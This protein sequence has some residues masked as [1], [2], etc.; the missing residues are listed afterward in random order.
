MEDAALHCQ[1]V[2]ADSLDADLADLGA[3]T[4]LPTDAHGSCNSSS[5]VHYPR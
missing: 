5:V 3:I 2:L 4:G 1:A